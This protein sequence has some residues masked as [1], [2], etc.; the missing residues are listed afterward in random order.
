LWQQI[1]TNFYKWLCTF[2]SRKVQDGPPQELRTVS[3]RQLWTMSP[4]NIQIGVVDGNERAAAL[5]ESLGF[6]KAEER[7]VFAR[8]H[9]RLK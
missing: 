9:R 3:D 6:Q 8:D 5:W 1:A 7:F 2:R 4:S